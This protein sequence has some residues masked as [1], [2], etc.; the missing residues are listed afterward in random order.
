MIPP[1]V[2]ILAFRN[3]SIGNTLV[4]IPAL[5]AI[6][7]RH[8]AARLS[9]VVDPVG[10]EL[11]RGCPWID[12][13][14]LYDRHGRDRSLA[15]WFRLVRKLRRLKPSHA[16][17]FKRFF[18][19]GLLARL[20]GAPIRIGFST[21]GRAPFLNHTIPYD[22]G[23]SITRLNLRLAALLDADEGDTHTEIWL[24]ATDRERAEDFL[25]GHGLE[26]RPFVAAHYGGT[27]TAPG[28]ASPERFGSLLR[29]VAGDSRP[30]LLIGSG[31]MESEWAAR[32]ARDLP[33]GTVAAQGLPL[34][35]TAAILGRSSLFV[36]F[37][38][39]PAHLAVA[40]GAPALILYRPDDRVEAEIRK[41]LPVSERVRPLVPP[42][43]QEEEAWSAFFEEAATAAAA[44]S[45]VATGLPGTAAGL[46]GVAGGP[47]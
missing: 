28:F 23:V 30:A 18:R 10:R 33:A 26:K 37:N 5:R 4:A 9:V 7:R 40:A 45:G 11:L 1:P 39:G 22:E 21:E 20:S 12:R 38:S 36:G 19:N 42:R 27:A 15:R 44:L 14:I 34:R 8:P 43:S 17:L 47:A 3:G 31:A 29:R 46:P 2:S 25:A 32:V 35:V 24:S 16:I 6:R 13:L 41:W